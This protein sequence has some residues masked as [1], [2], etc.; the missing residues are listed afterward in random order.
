MEKWCIF[1]M[2]RN[3]NHLKQVGIKIFTSVADYTGMS[4]DIH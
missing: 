2:N 1:N 3:A 4:N